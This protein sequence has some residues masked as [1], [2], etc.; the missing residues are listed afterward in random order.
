MNN[1][2]VI[3]IMTTAVEG[4]IKIGKTNNFE[5]RMRYLEQNGYW[6]VSGLQRFYAV[7]VQNYD[8]KERLIHTIFSKSQVA[9]SELFA[10]DKRVAKDMLES[11]DGEQVYPPV[12][13]IPEPQPGPAK[14]PKLTFDMIGIPIGST[15]EYISD[16]TVTCK[17]INLKS[18]VEYQGK[19]Y[20]LSGLVTH[21][22]NGGSWRGGAFFTYNGEKLTD[23]RKTQGK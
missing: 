8:D 16:S 3:Y 5:E 2:G 13:R 23:M 15:L 14:A 11:F 19:R 20:T 17:T 9:D 12:Q 1:T 21:L 7:R 18:G 6:N 22:R 4:L 10:L